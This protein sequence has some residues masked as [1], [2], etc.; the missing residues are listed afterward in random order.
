VKVLTTSAD[1]TRAIAAALS[2]Q[3]AAGDVVVLVG[4]LGAGKTTFAQGIARGLGVTVPVTS[5]TFTLV[6]QYSGRLP[7]A[8]VDVYRL[9]RVQELHDLG[10][11]ELVDGPGVTLIEWGD[12]VRQVLPA[13]HAVVRIEPGDSGDERVLT[14][15]FEGAR[16]R[17]RDI[18]GTLARVIPG[19]DGATG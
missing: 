9:D 5:P 17:A 8:H 16:W 13:D 10:F 12:A 3:L 11:E 2:V 6:Q 4:E 14:F 15:E 1:A 18:S 19:I 7:I